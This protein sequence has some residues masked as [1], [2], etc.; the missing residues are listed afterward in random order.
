VSSNMI[1]TTITIASLL[2]GV[3]GSHDSLA[4]CL[5]EEE[6]AE[7]Q[8]TLWN[9]ANCNEEGTGAITGLVVDAVCAISADNCPSKTDRNSCGASVGCTWDAGVCKWDNGGGCRSRTTKDACGADRCKWEGESCIWNRDAENNVCLHPPTSRTTLPAA[10][11]NC[12]D[13]LK[14]RCPLSWEVP[15]GCCLEEHSKYELLLTSTP[16]FVCCNAPCTSLEASHKAGSQ[17]HLFALTEVTTGTGLVVANQTVCNGN[18]GSTLCAPGMRSYFG[19]YSMGGGGGLMDK[20][21][22]MSTMGMYGG[23]P[24]YGGRVIGG[25][26]TLGLPGMGFMNQVDLDSE[27][28]LNS[29]EGHVEEISMDDFMETLIEALDTDADVFESDRQISSDPWFGKQKFSLGPNGIKFGNPMDIFNDIYGNP[30]FGFPGPM[31][32]MRPYGKGGYGGYGKGGYRGYGKGGFGGYGHGGYMGYGM[33][34]YGGYA[35]GDYG[36]FAKDG[37]GGNAK[38][39]HGDDAKDGHGGYGMG[40]FGAYG[41]GGYGG[42][43]MGGYG[44]YGMGGYGGYGMGGFGGYGMGGFGKGFWSPYGFSNYGPRPHVYGQQPPTDGQQPEPTDPTQDSEAQ[45]QEQP[46]EYQ[47]PQQQPVFAQQSAYQQPGYPRAPAYGH[48]QQS[49]YPQGA[50]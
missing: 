39:G 48:G 2:S 4:K 32:R 42:Y 26:G 29:K 30:G 12:A 47:P 9:K 3:L 49:S 24:M 7:A 8:D 41:M 6:V 35:K 19:A 33:G 44:G 36:G 22:Q 23:K 25:Y 15:T 45:Q 34:G 13:I 16:G 10:T 14:G 5:Y 20:N 11:K 46:A 21:M 1:V 17:V 50:W 28:G 40:G 38:D 27:E 43:G 18:M 37:H 31:K